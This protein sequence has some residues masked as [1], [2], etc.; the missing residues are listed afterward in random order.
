[1]MEKVG[2]DVG[3]PVVELGVHPRPAAAPGREPG[4]EEA[5]RRGLAALRRGAEARMTKKLS[6]PRDASP[7]TLARA[8]AGALG[9]DPRS[10][11]DTLTTTPADDAEFAELGARLREVESA[12]ESIDPWEKRSR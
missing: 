5:R 12:L 10:V 9:R 8:V 4:S 3:T 1:A 2:N 6:L 11:F 7:E